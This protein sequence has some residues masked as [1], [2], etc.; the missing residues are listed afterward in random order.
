MGR[1]K[2]LYGTE[3][4]YHRL[5]YIRVSI[6]PYKGRRGGTSIY[7][8]RHAWK[9]AKILDTIIFRYRVENFFLI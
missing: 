1:N 8:G 5:S 9:H 2:R 7:P 3:V 4:N 6:Y